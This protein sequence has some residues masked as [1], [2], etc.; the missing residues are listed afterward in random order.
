MLYKACC[1]NPESRLRFLA[2]ADSDFRAL[3]MARGFDCQDIYV[4]DIIPA[5]L[6][7]AAAWEISTI[8]DRSADP[9]EQIE[10]ATGR[11]RS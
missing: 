8:D 6:A 4:D 2:L 9:V 3:Q 7:S 1:Q 5:K 11:N 10:E